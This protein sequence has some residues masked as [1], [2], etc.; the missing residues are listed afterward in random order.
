MQFVVDTAGLK[1]GIVPENQ[2]FVWFTA[3]DDTLGIQDTLNYTADEAIHSTRHYIQVKQT[4]GCTTLDSLDIVVYDLSSDTLRVEDMTYILNYGDNFLY[5]D[6][7]IVPDLMHNGEPVPDSFIASA[8]HDGGAKIYPP[9]MDDLNTSVTWTITD[10]CGNVHV[11]SQNLHFEIP[12]CGDGVTVTDKDG[13]LYHSVRIGLNCWMK[14]NLRTTKYA[15]ETLVPVAMGYYAEGNTDSAANAATFGRLYTWYSATKVAE[16]DDSATPQVNEYGHVQG[17]CPDGW[18]LPDRESYAALHDIEMN[19][20]RE[21]GDAYWIDG[22]G[23]NTTNLSLR[24]SGCYN[25][26]TQRCENLRGNAYFWTSDEF[27]ATTVKSFMADC[28]CYSWQEIFQSKGNAF[29]VRCL[30]EKD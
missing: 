12:P 21:A 19:R 17:V 18:Y 14:E 28:H 25:L 29:S 5:S 11:K 8:V 30:K 4:G 26:S 15:D 10:K 13:N 9:S 3:N 27:D 20:L 23:N 6:S 1:F 2:R 7:L 22:G 16:N 24:G